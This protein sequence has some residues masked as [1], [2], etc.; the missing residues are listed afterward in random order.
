MTGRVILYHTYLITRASPT[1]YSLFENTSE[2]TT[3]HTRDTT[4]AVAV[5]TAIVLA[6]ASGSVVLDFHEVATF[7]VLLDSTRTTCQFLSR[8][9]A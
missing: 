8:Y 3:E 1:D 5:G 9:R 2:E 4:R 7:N 6:D